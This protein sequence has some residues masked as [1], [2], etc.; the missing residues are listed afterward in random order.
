M[1]VKGDWARGKINGACIRAC[2]N[3]DKM[4]IECWK[5]SNFKQIKEVI[6]LAKGKKPVK[7]AKM[8]MKKGCK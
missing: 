2:A 3:R 1:G 7:G 8:P 4:C 5:F 6:K